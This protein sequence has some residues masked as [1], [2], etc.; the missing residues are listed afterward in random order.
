[1]H[2]DLLAELYARYSRQLYLFIYALC[3]SKS[4][5]EDIMQET[6]ARAVLSLPDEHPN[7]A[8][9]L[10]TV[11]KNLC[12][13]E[14]KRQRRVSPLE[15]SISPQALFSDSAKSPE[16][17]AEF[18]EEVAALYAALLRLPD[19]MRAVITLHYFCGLPMNQIAQVVDTSPG[20]VRVLAVRGRQTLKKLLTEGDTTY[21]L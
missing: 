15:E 20:N 4:E 21:E 8:A 18:N 11:G 10:Y 1:M 5:A 3:R 6:F 7:F 12:L 17:A 19:K 9:W 16:N 2:K 14:M 13:S